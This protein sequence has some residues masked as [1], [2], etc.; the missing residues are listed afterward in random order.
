MRRPRFSVAV[1]HSQDYTA[2]VHGRTQIPVQVSDPKPI[3]V[4]SVQSIQ[5]TRV[6]QLLRGRPW[7]GA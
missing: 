5:L 4:S 2:G 7:T 6:E 3:N 1:G